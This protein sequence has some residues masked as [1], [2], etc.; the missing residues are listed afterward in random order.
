MR[1]RKPTP[2]LLRALHGNPRKHA[3]PAGEPKPVGDLAEAPEWL[4]DDQRANWSYALEHAPPGLLKRIDQS[5]LA[6]W[7]VAVD[8]HRQAAKAQA[9]VGLIVRVKT[10]A[11]IG[12]DD[13]GVPTASPYINILNQQAKI[14]L[15]AADELGFSPVARPRTIADAATPG[16]NF[17]S[18]ARTRADGEGVGLSLDDYLAAAPAPPKLN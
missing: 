1:G 14:I 7:A 17:G 5:I 12:R 15:K 6:V 4:S 18:G 16:A 8:L 9:G 13:P 10:K 11:T 2:T 3:L